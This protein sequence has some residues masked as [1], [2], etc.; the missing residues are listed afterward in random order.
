MRRIV[1]LI[2]LIFLARAD[3]IEESV[4]TISGVNE[5]NCSI[6]I[7]TPANAIL[8][9][10][11]QNAFG[12]FNATAITGNVGIN[13]T[14]NGS[15][16]LSLDKTHTY[17]N[18]LETESIGIEINVPNGTTSGTYNQTIN[19]F[20][21]ENQD[22]EII[23]IEVTTT[24]GRIN[25]RV[26]NT[27]NQPVNNAEISLFGE[28]TLASSETGYTDNTGKWL[29]K[30]HPSGDYIAKI[31]KTGHKTKYVYITL[32]DQETI[33]E[34]IEIE[35]LN[36]P[37]N[38]PSSGSKKSSGMSTG[39]AYIPQEPEKPEI[40]IIELPESKSTKQG[41]TIFFSVIVNNTGNTILKNISLQT[42]K[43]P[44]TIT[45]VSIEELAPAAEGIFLVELNIPEKTT[46]GNHIIQ[47][48]TSSEKTS[49]TA[50]T[51]INIKEKTQ[52]NK[53]K[54]PEEKENKSEIRESIENLIEIT[55]KAWEIAIKEQLKGKNTEEV[56][57]LLEE[58]LKNFQEALEKPKEESTLKEQGKE[59]LKEAIIKLS[60]LK[61][62]EYKCPI[63]DIKIMGLC[64][65][66]W[67]QDIIILLLIALIIHQ[68]K[69]LKKHVQKRKKDIIQILKGELNWKRKKKKRVRLE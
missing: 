33:V 47:V 52:P 53:T 49:D 38:P 23:G 14:F 51:M 43:F 57:K 69:L 41:S 44:S 55:E 39:G 3:T 54:P 34:T 7:S 40:K 58:A 6:S 8:V 48:K 2:L 56:I 29:S 21:P 12:E 13:V 59:K 31:S 42:S 20:G 67:I 46:T 60:E 30:W 35:E 28:S 10:P 68:R 63:I 65:L 16:W 15:S 45:P 9:P 24:V 1:L 5:K 27:R 22:N 32:T 37:D 18:K 50:E 25:L 11:S 61:Y 64:I 26:E 66:W 19:G 36:P 62:P 17:L 4:Q